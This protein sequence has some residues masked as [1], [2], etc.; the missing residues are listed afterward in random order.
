VHCRLIREGGN[1]C[2]QLG[3]HSDRNSLHGR[4][5]LFHRRLA[6]G[7]KEKS[8]KKTPGTVAAVAGMSTKNRPT[9]HSPPQ[10]RRKD[11]QRRG[12]R[13]ALAP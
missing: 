3:N 12:T 4:L 13:V 7:A 1:A 6:A 2:A 9:Q 8:K 5:V 10:L 11:R